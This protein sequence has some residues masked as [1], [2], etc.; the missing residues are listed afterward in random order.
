MERKKEKRNRNY[1]WR[2]HTQLSYLHR[3]STSK[4][5]H[6]DVCLVSYLQIK[7]QQRKQKTKQKSQATASCYINWQYKVLLSKQSDNDNQ[8]NGSESLTAWPKPFRKKCGWGKREITTRKRKGV[9]AINNTVNMLWGVAF[10][11]CN[12]LC[13]TCVMA[14]TQ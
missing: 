4:Q 14:N 1:H 9:L 10:E 3:S 7:H 12:L 5:D 8:N 11:L 13:N 6:R 2:H